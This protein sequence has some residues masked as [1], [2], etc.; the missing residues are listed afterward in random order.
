[1]SNAA[2]R[3]VRGQRL[4]VLGL[5]TQLVERRSRGAILENLRILT[6]AEQIL[7][8]KK[9][10]LIE[11]KAAE[12]RLAIQ[13]DELIPS[14][15]V[16]EMIIVNEENE[17]T[18]TDV[19]VLF[20]EDEANSRWYTFRNVPLALARR[21]RQGDAETKTEDRQGGYTGRNRKMWVKGKYPSAGAF[22]NKFI[23]GRF[24][25]VRGRFW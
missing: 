3:R 18:T 25:F 23:K 24:T 19:Q 20:G 22:F 2:Q 17:P 6:P 14:S 12:A 13:N 11:G 15:W 9:R 16:L 8:R 1:M 7:E 10:A 4:R 5:I 21:W